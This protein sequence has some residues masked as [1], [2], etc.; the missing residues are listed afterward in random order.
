MWSVIPAI[1][2]SHIDERTY[3]S[4]GSMLTLQIAVERYL[5]TLKLKNGVCA[6]RRR[7]WG[8]LEYMQLRIGTAQRQMRS[9]L[10]A[11]GPTQPGRRLSVNKGSQMSGGAGDT[12]DRYHL[13]LAPPNSWDRSGVSGHVWAGP[14]PCVV[15]TVKDLKQSP[16]SRAT[17]RRNKP[18]HDGGGKKQWPPSFLITHQALRT[19]STVKPAPMDT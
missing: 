16:H 1:G 13:T 17:D 18:H 19:T 11:S 10:W 14:S 5:Q 3:S 8:P 15:S 9:N 12:V 7:K 4:P 6:D 2:H